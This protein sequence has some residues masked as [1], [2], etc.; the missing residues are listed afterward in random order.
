MNTQLLFYLS[1]NMFSANRYMS[2][3]HQLIC[4]PSIIRAILSDKNYGYD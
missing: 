4:L 3:K 1:L 2:F